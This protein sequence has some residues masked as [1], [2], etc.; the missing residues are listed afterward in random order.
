MPAQAG[1]VCYL[2]NL[3]QVVSETENPDVLVVGGGNAALCAALAAREQGASVLLIESA[4]RELRSGNSRH[5]RNLRC[6]HNAPTEVLSDEYREE[7]YYTDLLRVTGGQT[8][9]Q[10]RDARVRA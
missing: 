2:I 9:E 4:P 3:R 8:D 5:T 1:F 7:E 6:M 10:G